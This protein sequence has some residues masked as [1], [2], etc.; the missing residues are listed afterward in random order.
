MRRSEA[1]TARA[2]ARTVERSRDQ[3][4]RGVVDS[5]ARAVNER[6]EELPHYELYVEYDDD[7]GLW[8]DGSKWRPGVAIV[9]AG[10]VMRSAQRTGAM[11]PDE[12]CPE[13]IPDADEPGVVVGL[14]RAERP[15]AADGDDASSG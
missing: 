3:Q 12:R 2:A 6:G 9:V 10:D 5:F 4:A 15:Q 14:W 1:D 8:P 11:P 7:P 13:R